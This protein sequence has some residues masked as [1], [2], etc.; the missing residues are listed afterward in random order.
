MT[1]PST[2]GESADLT[3]P[4]RRS[5]YPDPNP[6]ADLVPWLKPI[7]T[8]GVPAATAVYLTWALV[9]Y[10]VPALQTGQ[11]T[12][13]TIVAML[14]SQAADHQAMKAQNDQMIL[15]LRA[16]CINTAKDVVERDR[17]NGWTR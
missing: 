6:P 1:P 8:L 4:P 11:N 5:R 12:M 14:G 7:V 15:I 17:C 3:P 13:N 10:V 9:Q 16:S 2:L